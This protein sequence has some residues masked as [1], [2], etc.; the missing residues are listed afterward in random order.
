MDNTD[1][2]QRIGVTQQMLADL[3]EDGRAIVSG[4]DVFFIDSRGRARYRKI[5]RS[6]PNAG[7]DHMLFE[8]VGPTDA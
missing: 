5:A 1:W 6:L 3:E 4:N 2:P 8:L 7:I